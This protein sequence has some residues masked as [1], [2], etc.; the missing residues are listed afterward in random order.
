MNF[1]LWLSAALI[2]AGLVFA[3]CRLAK[4]ARI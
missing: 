2:A 4:I 1:Y 3:I